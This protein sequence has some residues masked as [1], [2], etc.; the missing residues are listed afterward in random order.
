MGSV[1]TLGSRVLVSMLVI[2][3]QVEAAAIGD[4]YVD[5]SHT[6]PFLGTPTNPYQKITDAL[7]SPRLPAT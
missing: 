6:G 7:D 3:L 1:R 4:L 2:A 5:D